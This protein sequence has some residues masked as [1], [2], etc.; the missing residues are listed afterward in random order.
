MSWKNKLYF[1]DNLTILRD[2][3]PDESVDLI[4]LDPPF[5]SAANYN[6]LFA[7]KSGQKSAAQIA[8]FEDTW[9]WNVEQS[10]SAYSEIVYGG[11]KLADLMSALLGFLGKNDMLAYLVMMA[12]RLRELH[13][14]LK[15]TGSLYLHCDPTAS[16]YLKLILD[17]VF[18]TGGFRNEIVWRRTSGRKGMTQFGRVHDV[19]FFYTKSTMWTWNPSTVPLT[20]DN[21]RG[22]DILREGDGKVYRLSDLSGAGQGP[23]RLFGDREIPPPKGRHWMFDQEGID[24][25]T[26]EGRIH[27]TS[28]GNPR[29]K[30]DIENLS[31]I[32]VHDVWNDIEPI[33]AAAQERLGYPTQKPEAL[34]ER[35]ISASSNDGDVV[36]DPFC[37]CGTA[38]AVSEKLH[39]RWIGI[40]ITHLAITLIRHRLH[41][42]FGSQLSGYEI[43]GAPADVGGAEALAAQDRYQFQWWALGLVDAR[44][45]SGLNKKGA[46]KGVDG[47]IYF[48]DDTSGKAKRVLVQVKSG[49]V[50][51]SDIATLKSDVERERAEIGVFVTLEEPSGPMKTEA[52]VAGYYEPEYAPE[53]RVPKIQLLTI[54]DLLAGA[55][56]ALPRLAPIDTFKKAPKQR[57]GKSPT[58]TSIF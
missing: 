45:A 9:H 25:L 50:K 5:N 39:R 24:K 17:A 54:S 52:A 48:L 19:I 10:E 8:A 57:K 31:G 43:L 3:V 46:D 58:Q 26:E 38:V 20:A 23:S 35:I 6:V 33:N 11:G 32:A 37:G 14:V 27:F 12:V 53:Q 7:D 18:G 40:D 22:H 21:I 13:R 41:N 34:L 30:T 2:E 29:I 42:T 28:T 55:R 49:G 1:G 15:P 4:Y 51:R 47:F 36:L 16:H 56:V 44:P